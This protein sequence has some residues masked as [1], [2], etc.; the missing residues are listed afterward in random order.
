MT[1]FALG[2]VLI[3]AVSHA[4]WNLLA[5]RASRGA[6]FTWL[7]DAL[8]VGLY[9]PVAAA[10]VA[11]QRP[12]LGPRDLT[13]ML[14]SAV[15]HLGYFLL[16]QRGYRSGDLSVV[17]PL[18][19][20]VGPMLSTVG[21]IVLLGERPTGL[22]LAGAA[23]I[24]I[25]VVV[26]S[27][28]PAL[29]PRSGARRSIAYAVAT[30]V[31]IAAYTLWDKQ[32]VSASGVGAQP[33]VYFWGFTALRVLL[34]TPFALRHRRDV[35]DGWRQHRREA[36]GIALLSPL[37][38]ILVLVALVLAPV[39]YV[40]PAREIGIL[41]GVVL[42][43]RMLLEGEAARRLAAGIVMVAGVAALALG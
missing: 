18:A 39:S 42:G 33:V 24:G 3:S 16:L 28:R 9:A 15:L 34:L 27:A 35:L 25:G 2:L 12:V 23:M 5:K 40:A 26:L 20:G 11:L 36:L 4:T 29:L 41:I 38:Y 7:F 13:F 14:G 31:L 17:Y 6:A 1:A 21:A 19:R 22:A 8:A 32:A 30:G 43:T 10:V 37:S